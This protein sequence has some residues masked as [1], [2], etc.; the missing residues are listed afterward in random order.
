MILIVITIFDLNGIRSLICYFLCYDFDFILFIV[1]AVEDLTLEIFED[2]LL[3]LTNC[4][5]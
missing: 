5:C 2:E 3:F 1:S 4:Q